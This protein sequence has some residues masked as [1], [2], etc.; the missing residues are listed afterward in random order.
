MSGGVGEPPTR[1][2]FLLGKLQFD[3]DVVV[4]LQCVVEGSGHD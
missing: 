4:V 1:R 2:T 3:Q